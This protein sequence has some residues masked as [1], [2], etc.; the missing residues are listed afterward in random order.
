[1][2][3]LSMMSDAGRSLRRVGV[4]VCVP[5]ALIAGAVFLTANVQRSAVEHAAQ[6][7][8]TSESMLNAIL[9]QESG[10]RG[11]Y[12]L[13][14]Q[15]S[16]QPWHQGTSEFASSLAQL[17]SLVSGNSALERSLAR[18]AK[19]ATAWHDVTQAEILTV[20]RTGRSPSQAAI[21]KDREQMLD[22][23][24]SNTAFDVALRKASDHALSVASAVA[25]AIVGALAAMLVGIVLLLTRRTARRETARHR[26]QAQLRELLQASE[27][28]QESRTL[29]IRHIHALLPDCDP[30]ALTLNHDTD[31]L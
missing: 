12:E 27:S 23:R 11:F 20:Q 10:A 30:A 6:Q 7:Q 16:L 1:M 5:V 25:A 31:L 8:E 13:H 24:A 2:G 18:Q 29:L 3:V 9:N 17:R 14:Q 4:L 19:Q 26:D 15:A 22:F 21:Q 28:E